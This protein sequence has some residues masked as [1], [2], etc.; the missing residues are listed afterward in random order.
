RGVEESVLPFCLQHNI[1][2]IVY[3]PMQA[4]LLTGKMT[5]ERIQ[6]LPADDWRKGDEEYQ[7]PRLSKNLRLADAM[8]NIAK[9]HNVP[10]PNVSIAWVLNHPA[11]T[12]A[13]VGVR[14]PKQADEVVGGGTLKLTEQDLQEIEMASR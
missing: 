10:V 13:I 11:V 2:V 12:G 1:G 8:V 9:R 5:R 6:N 7:E 3:S 14:N 4:G